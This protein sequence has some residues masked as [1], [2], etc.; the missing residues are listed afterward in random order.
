MSRNL[1]FAV[2][3]GLVLLGAIDL[4]AGL[5][6][7]G[8]GEAAFVSIAQSFMLLFPG[9]VFFAYSMQRI[10]RLTSMSRDTLVSVEVTA[11]E[12]AV[13]VA[14]SDNVVVV[15]P[16]RGGKSAGGRSGYKAQSK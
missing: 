4:Y 1:S 11:E 9:Y 2:G 15:F 12:G 8:L 3:T 14:M 13:P 10:P 5:S 6:Q 7:Q 16:A